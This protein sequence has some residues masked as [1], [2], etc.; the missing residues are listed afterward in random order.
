M[1]LS[2]QQEFHFL[3]RI[4][5][6]IFEEIA[7]ESIAYSF[8]LAFIVRINCIFQNKQLE[9]KFQIQFNSIQV[10]TQSNP[11]IAKTWGT[12]QLPSHQ[13]Q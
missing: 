6:E 12:N 11:K 8:W 10:F 4:V 1:T 13:K 7:G 5:F 2:S 3:P 9:P